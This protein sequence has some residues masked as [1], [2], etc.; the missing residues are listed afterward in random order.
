MSTVKNKTKKKNIRKNKEVQNT[1]SKP[2]VA[3]RKDMLP[4]TTHS[5]P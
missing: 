1:L 2:T 5:E 4:I 3:N